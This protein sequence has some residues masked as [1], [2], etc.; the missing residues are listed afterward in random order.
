[1]AHDAVPDLEAEND[2]QQDQPTR[3]E[4]PFPNRWGSTTTAEALGRCCGQ[5]VRHE[6]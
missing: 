4:N 3:V 2:V 1:M 6:L 5:A